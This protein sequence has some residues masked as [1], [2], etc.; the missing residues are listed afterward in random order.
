MSKYPNLDKLAA[1]LADELCR[2][3]NDQAPKIESEMPYKAQYTLE[4]IIKI[5]EARV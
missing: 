5:L 1:Q 4:E 2:K 3:I